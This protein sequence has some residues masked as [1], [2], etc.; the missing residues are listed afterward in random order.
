MQH[1][2]SDSKGRLPLGL[3]FANMVFIVDEKDPNE[4][5]IKK[6][7][8]ISAKE[9]WLHKNPEAISSVKR[10]LEQAKHKKFAKDPISN[11]KNMS[12]LDEIED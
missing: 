5:I 12:W 3:E 10:G 1:K 2:K 11:K 8:I 9:M 4:I 6:A 7:I